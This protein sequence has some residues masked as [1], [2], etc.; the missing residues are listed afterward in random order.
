MET[1]F[2]IT[3]VSWVVTQNL[4][5]FGLEIARVESLHAADADRAFAAFASSARDSRS[6]SSFPDG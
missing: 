5:P 4:V 6:G 3:R 1:A 2:V